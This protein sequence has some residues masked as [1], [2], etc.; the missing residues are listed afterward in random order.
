VSTPDFLVVGAARSG[1]TALVEALRA[2]PA[3][4]VTT[5][6]EPHY[7]ALHGTRPAFTGPGD[8]SFNA[9]VVTDTEAYL[10]LFADA[11]PG[12]LV[13][14]GSTSTLYHHRTAIPEIRRLAPDARLVALLRDP[15]ARAV[16]AYDYLASRGL[17]TAPDPVA[18]IDAEPARIEAGYHHL[19]HYVAMGR[20]AE[21]VA[22]FQTAFG[23]RFRV[24]FHDEL[25][26]DPAR[27]LAEVRDFLGAPPGPPVAVPQVN[28]S[29]AAR[30]RLARRALQGLARSERRRAAVK[31]V[32]PFR[33]REAVRTVLLR[34]SG[35]DAAVERRLRPEFTED[36]RRLR[37]LVGTGRPLP[38]WLET[39]G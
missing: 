37:E 21:Q 1:T 30:S 24:W 15:V 27:V 25:T 5:P 4:W 28:A 34:R 19:W 35:T 39:P 9:G 20:Y 36:L 14:E 8:D 12:Q 31:A 23:D 7:L 11:R 26:E 18:A 22:A 33:A 3:F 13:G 16:S 6:K 17:E 38:P 32:V 29:G 10:A 2:D